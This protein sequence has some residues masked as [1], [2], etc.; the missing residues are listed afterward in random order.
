MT[1]NRINISFFQQ[2]PT[3]TESTTTNIECLEKKDYRSDRNRS[4]EKCT[5]RT[6]RNNIGP[7][8]FAVVKDKPS[9]DPRT[10]RKRKTRHSNNPPIEHHVGW[11]FD[12]REHRPRTYST[13]YVVF[14]N[15]RPF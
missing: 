4:N 15:N 1:T 10:P 3:N 5:L 12:V 14:F 9:V 2:L 11:I 7:R 8:F 6:Q 13:E